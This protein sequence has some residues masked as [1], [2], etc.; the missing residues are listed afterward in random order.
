MQELEHRHKD[1][2]IVIETLSV[3]DNDG[4][5]YIFDMAGSTWDDVRQFIAAGCPSDTADEYGGT[6][7]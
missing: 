1:A 2:K 3:T 4:N 5:I 6:L 7:L